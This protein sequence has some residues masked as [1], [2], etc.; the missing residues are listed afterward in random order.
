MK[1]KTTANLNQIRSE[2]GK[3]DKIKGIKSLKNL[4]TQISRTDSDSLL[5][6]KDAKGI[7]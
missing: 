1:S 4:Q 2:I 3:K 5:K 6:N 7:Y